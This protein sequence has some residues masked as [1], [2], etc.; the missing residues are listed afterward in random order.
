[1]GRQIRSTRP[2]PEETL[3][4]QWP[5]LKEFQKIDES[6]KLKQNRNLNQR[7]RASKLPSFDVDQPVFVATREDTGTVPGRVIQET[8]GTDLMK[9]RHQQELSDKIEVI[10]ML[11]LKTYTY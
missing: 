7:H 10:F 8:I 9:S 6:F 1:M 2:T 5:D 3:V 4:P 11:D